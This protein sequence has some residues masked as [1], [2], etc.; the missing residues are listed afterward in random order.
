MICGVGKT[1]GNVGVSKNARFSYALSLSL[2]HDETTAFRQERRVMQRMERVHT[3][4]EN[5]VKVSFPQKEFTRLI[6]L[7]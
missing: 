6:S 5:S 2:R 4:H 1:L 7:I 3:K